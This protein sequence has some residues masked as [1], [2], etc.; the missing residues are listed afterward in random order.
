MRLKQQHEFC[1]HHTLF[2]DLGVTIYIVS[3]MQHGGKESPLATVVFIN[4]FPLTDNDTLQ[5]RCRMLHS[6]SI[7]LALPGSL[8]GTESFKE[9]VCEKRWLKCIYW[10]LVVSA[11]TLHSYIHNNPANFQLPGASPTLSLCLTPVHFIHNSHTE[12]FLK[13]AALPAYNLRQMLHRDNKSQR[14][15]ANA[16]SWR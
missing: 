11:Q 3:N 14:S 6:A 5:W 1:I 12:P 15:P 2:C 10:H 16:T 9:L 4:I 7:L 8:S 13:A